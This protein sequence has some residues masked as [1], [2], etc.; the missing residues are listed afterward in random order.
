MGIVKGRIVFAREKLGIFKG[1][2]IMWNGKGGFV[3]EGGGGVENRN[4]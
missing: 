4:D 1:G 3:F 2:I